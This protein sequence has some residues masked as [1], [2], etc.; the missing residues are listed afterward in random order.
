[1]ASFS[2]PKGDFLPGG[3]AMRCRVPSMFAIQEM[4]PK[5]KTAPRLKVIMLLKVSAMERRTPYLVR[6]LSVFVAR[7]HTTGLPT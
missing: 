2:D 1:M 3:T 7:P 4:V 5:Q 6:Q